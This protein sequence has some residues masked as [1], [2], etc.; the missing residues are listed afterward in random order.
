M[1]RTII[2][3]GEA[4][5]FSPVTIEKL[6]WNP[7]GAVLFSVMDRRNYSQGC[8]ASLNVA[9]GKTPEGG[10]LQITLTYHPPRLIFWY[11]MRVLVASFP[12][13]EINTLEVIP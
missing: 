7:T 3:N 6:K 1:E 13:A 5:V 12:A 11:H 4:H 2:V 9:K 8:Y 10:T